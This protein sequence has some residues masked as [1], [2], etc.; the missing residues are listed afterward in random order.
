[1]AHRTPDRSG[2]G[3]GGDLGRGDPT[4]ESQPSLYAPGGREMLGPDQGHDGPVGTGSA[5]A[6][7]SMDVVGRVGG[8]IEVDDQRD[9]I[10]V[11]P[12]RGDVGGHQYVQPASPE[13]GQGPLA[14]ALAAITVDGGRRQT[15]PSET[16][17]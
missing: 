13:C 6:P 5:G 9:G 17:R 10:H 14:L 8:G 11:D 4:R 16:L 3:K 12:A 7:R 15:R 2:G 1:M